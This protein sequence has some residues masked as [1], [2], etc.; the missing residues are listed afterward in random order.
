MKKTVK[1]YILRISEA[2]LSKIPLI[3]NSF[4]LN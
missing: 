3:Q 1:N 4:K 2:Q